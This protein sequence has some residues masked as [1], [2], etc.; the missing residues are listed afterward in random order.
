M[1]RL[2]AVAAATR[3]RGVVRRVDDQQLPGQ[4]WSQ[5]LAPKR[6]D[7]SDAS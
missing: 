6:I 2:D 3:R 7:R 4:H 1:L 5:P